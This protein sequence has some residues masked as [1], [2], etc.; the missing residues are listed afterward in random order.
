[1]P[2]DFSVIIPT[3]RRN[4]ELREAIASVQR[5]RDVTLEILVV[6]DSPE[7]AARVVAEGFDD[8]RITY[9]ANPQPTGGFPSIVRNLA[10]PRASGTFVHFLDDDDR[11]PEG[12]YARA[13]TAFDRHPEVGLVFGRIAPF[14]ACPPAQLRRELAFFADAARRARLCGRLGRRLAF[15][16]QMLFDRPLLVCSAGILR[17]ASVE[18]V[19]GFDP[20]IRLMEDAEFYA[21]VMRSCGAHFLDEVVLDYRIGSPSLMHAPDPPPDQVRAQRAGRRRMQAKYRRQH[22]ALEFYALAAATRLVMRRL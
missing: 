19:G 6:D 5:Q 14:G 2:V 11:V 13:R 16:G 10:W 1:M 12:H 9:L 20:D 18:R 4:G 21:R 3:F 17:R 7:A 8:P 22:G 15:A